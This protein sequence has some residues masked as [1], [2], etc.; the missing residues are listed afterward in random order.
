VPNYDD[1]ASLVVAVLIFVVAPGL[2]IAAVLYVVLSIRQLK[3][4]VAWM[5][6]RQGGPAPRQRQVVV[7]FRRRSG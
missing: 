6:W 2:L 3:D 1:I 5:V 7:P 4:A